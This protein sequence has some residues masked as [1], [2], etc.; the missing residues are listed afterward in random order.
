MFE[1]KN[2]RLLRAGIKLGEMKNGRFEPD[3]ALAMCVKKKEVK[4]TVNYPSDDPRIE[5]FLRG[6]TVEDGSVKNGWLVVCADGYP[7]G[8]GKGVNG[9][10]KNHIPKGLRKM[11]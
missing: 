6:E 2:L 10:I 11:K 5:K 3:H 8:L 9:V 1:W 7:I 4:N